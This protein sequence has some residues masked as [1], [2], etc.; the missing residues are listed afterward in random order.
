[1]PYLNLV[2]VSRP[3]VLILGTLCLS[4]GCMADQQVTKHAR[5][6]SLVKSLQK[7]TGLSTKEIHVVLKQAKPKPEIL[8]FFDRPSTSK[9]WYEY[10]KAVINTSRIQGGKRLHRSHA[11][12][13][14]KVARTYRVPEAYI[15][16]ILGVET[17]Y[18]RNTGKYRVLDVLTTLSLDYPRRSAYFGSELAQL[19]RLSREDHQPPTFYKGSFAGAMG[20]PQFMPSNVRS[21]SVDFDANG[22][23][24][25]WNSVLDITA[26][27]ANYFRHHGWQTPSERKPFVMKLRQWRPNAQSQRWFRK[28]MSH[29][30]PLSVWAQRG[31]PVPSHLNK[32]DKALLFR[33]EVAPGQFEYYWGFD[34]FRSVWKYNNSI[35]YVM[36]VYELARRLEGKSP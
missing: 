2:N 33:L 14:S 5:Y 17:M 10:R 25:L 32:G 7:K 9:P 11:Q 8:K 6:P 22:K 23:R 12:T 21:L 35:N 1:M 13:L 36:S 19:I 3:L 30:A 18:G 29:Y 16:A 20:W 4:S 31:L 27:I 24:D 34:A 28:P 26:S 15:L